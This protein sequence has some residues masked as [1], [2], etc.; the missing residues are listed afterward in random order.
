LGAP[1]SR[2]IGSPTSSA[3]AGTTSPLTVCC[4]HAL[5]GR[6]E[7]VMA[8]SPAR[9]CLLKRHTFRHFSDGTRAHCGRLVACFGLPQSAARLR[10]VQR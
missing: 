3:S 8:S 2:R 5:R 4:V 10:S 9:G 7:P 6:L 1:W